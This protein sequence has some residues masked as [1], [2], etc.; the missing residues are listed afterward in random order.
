MKMG[1]VAIIEPIA[2]ED[3]DLALHAQLCAQR[4]NQLLDK[5]DRVDQ[6]LDG[7]EVNLAEIKT[8]ITGDRRDNTEKYLKWAGTI[9][10]ILASALVGLA[11]HI[12]TKI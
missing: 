2:G 9:I 5:F 3:T 1:A 8:T 7:I 12:L 11:T 4:Y 6:R 10:V